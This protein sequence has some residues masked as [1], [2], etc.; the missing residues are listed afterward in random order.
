MLL[1]IK[2]IVIH[3]VNLGHTNSKHITHTHTYTHAYMYIK[4]TR[5]KATNFTCVWYLAWYPRH[6]HTHTHLRR[7]R[8]K[9]SF[10]TKWLSTILLQSVCVSPLKRR[11]FC[12]VTLQQL[13]N[14]LMFKNKLLTQ[15]IKFSQVHHNQNLTLSRLKVK[16]L[17]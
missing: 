10:F 16:I 1:Y 7:T 9:L 11:R 5:A 17:Y 15:K 2:P 3:S 8:T 12:A 4:N 13:T 14:L 6:T